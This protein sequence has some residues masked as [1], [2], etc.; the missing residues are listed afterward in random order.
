MSPAV[1][2][3]EAALSAPMVSAG[4]GD[5][6]S[7]V[8]RALRVG[9]LTRDSSSGQTLHSSAVGVHLESTLFDAARQ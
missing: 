6:L 1:T 9:V 4:R 5:A 7:V 8:H 3:I 2:A